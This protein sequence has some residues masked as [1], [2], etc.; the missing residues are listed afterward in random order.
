MNAIAK[1]SLSLSLIQIKK[2]YM[3]YMLYLPEY[4]LENWSWVDKRLEQMYCFMD[5]KIKYEKD[6]IDYDV[7]NRE[8]FG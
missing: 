6:V 4:E 3:T 8:T 1:Q 2:E 5:Y 7:K